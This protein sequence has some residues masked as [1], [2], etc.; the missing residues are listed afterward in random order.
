[1]MVLTG[2]EFANA[3]DRSIKFPVE[4]LFHQLGIGLCE[5]TG[6][7]DLFIKQP[8]REVIVYERGLYTPGQRS[9]AI[10]VFAHESQ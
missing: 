3:L 1:M 8:L 7:S 2:P 10:T 9:N 6:V 5:I 4:Q